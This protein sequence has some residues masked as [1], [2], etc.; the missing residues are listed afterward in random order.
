M[1]DK[2]TCM[3]HCRA[4]ADVVEAALD[5]IQTGERQAIVLA[6][7]IRPD[8]IVL[9]ERKARRIATDRG[10]NVIGTLGILTTAAEKGLITLREAL[11]DL[12]QTNFRAS[13]QLFESLSQNAEVQ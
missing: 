2:Q 4:S 12:K 13:S 7:L 9:D 3:A 6:E 11:D 1:G 5:Q 8:F 10:L